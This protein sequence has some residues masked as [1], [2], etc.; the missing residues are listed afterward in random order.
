[1]V[2]TTR[3]CVSAI[4]RLGDLVHEDVGILK[5]EFLRMTSMNSPIA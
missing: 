4:K 5:A 2:Y 1:M 3:P